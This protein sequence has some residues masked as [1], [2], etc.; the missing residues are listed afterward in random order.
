MKDRIGQTLQI[1]DLVVAGGT[2]DKLMVGN[3]IKITPKM[4]RI[5]SENGPEY[6]RRHSAV[7]VINT[8]RE[9]KP[10]LFV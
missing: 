7:I 2:H 8:I 3:I 5:K 6:L 1:N 4:V 10:E 9:Q